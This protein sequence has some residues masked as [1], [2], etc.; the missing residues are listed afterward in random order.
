MACRIDDDRAGRLTGR[1]VDRPTQERGIDLGELDCGHAELIV[2]HLGIKRRILPRRRR[3]ER[4]LLA[5]ARTRGRRAPG[6]LLIVMRLLLMVLRRLGLRGLLLLP[7]PG[8]C[9][10]RLPVGPRISALPGPGVLVAIT[11]R[12]G[13]GR[14]TD[15]DGGNG[16]QS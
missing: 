5:L 7:L 15:D 2:V 8:R 11:L 16:G 4:G 6:L 13:G 3:I 1:V 9:R 12:G 10:T 14:E